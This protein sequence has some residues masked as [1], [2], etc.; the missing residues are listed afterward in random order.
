MKHKAAA[1]DARG[2][3]IL[4]TQE[5]EWISPKRQGTLLC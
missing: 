2:G 4:N 1:P 5:E 3:A